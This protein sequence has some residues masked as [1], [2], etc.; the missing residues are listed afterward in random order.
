MGIYNGRVD[1]IYRDTLFGLKTY[2]IGDSKYYEIGGE[3]QPDSVYKQFAYA[4]NVQT[5]RMIE[6]QKWQ[7]DDVQ[8]YNE[9]TGGYNVI[10]N[11][12]IR[13]IWTGDSEKMLF[14]P[15]NAKDKEVWH[16]ENRLFDRDTL[17]IYTFEVDFMQVLKLYVNG[18][19]GERRLWRKEARDKIKKEVRLKLGKKY[20]FY[21]SNNNCKDDAVKKWF[22]ENWREWLGKIYKGENGYILAIKKDEKVSKEELPDYFNE[23]KIEEL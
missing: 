19:D 5:L 13:G 2:F 6:K 8:I 12:F 21:Q 11:F 22:D 16:F 3:I 7:V 10:P 15:Y 18:N 9:E 14:E 17:S 1:H 23:I 4:R 20:D